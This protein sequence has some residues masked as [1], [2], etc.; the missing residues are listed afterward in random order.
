MKVGLED[1]SLRRCVQ[2][3]M[4]SSSTAS[5]AS[6]QV[7]MQND[8]AALGSKAQAPESC[9]CLGSS[10]ERCTMKTPKALLTVSRTAIY[11]PKRSSERGFGLHSA[12]TFWSYASHCW[13]LVIPHSA[14]ALPFRCSC[15]LGSL[16][17]RPTHLRIHTPRSCLS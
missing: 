4:S 6:K 2:L 9:N 17:L 10:L 15:L 11:W 12:G 14:P 1:D 13:C 3:A 5:P 8:D 16:N 7:L